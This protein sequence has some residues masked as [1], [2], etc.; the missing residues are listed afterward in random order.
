MW[1]MILS[2][3]PT[4]TNPYQYLVRYFSNEQIEIILSYEHRSEQQVNALITILGMEEF[5]DAQLK[6]K[7]MKIFEVET[8]NT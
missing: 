6:A 1:N 2:N 3:L 7:V 5:C 8:T 4:G